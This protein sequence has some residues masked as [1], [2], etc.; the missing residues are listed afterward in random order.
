LLPARI[1]RGGIGPALPRQVRDASVVSPRL[2][3]D[4]D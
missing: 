3:P 2:L 4:A 1:P